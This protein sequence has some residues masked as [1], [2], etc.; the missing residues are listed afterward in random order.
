MTC[1][2]ATCCICLTVATTFA[3]PIVLTGETG[4]LTDSLSEPVVA[5]QDLIARREHD[6]GAPDLP[7]EAPH[8]HG[9]Q[10]PQRANVVPFP[11]G[12]TGPTG[13]SGDGAISWN[14]SS[15]EQGGV[16]L[17]TASDWIPLSART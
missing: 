6:R 15:T 11:T 12:P 8:D 1:R 5:V 4:Y 9:P 17:S 13:G 7:E 10:G 14:T 16:Y 3:A 2:D